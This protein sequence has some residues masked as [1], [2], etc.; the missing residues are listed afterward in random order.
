MAATRKKRSEVMQTR[1]E[2]G[3]VSL[4]AVGV[5]LGICLFFEVLGLV[6]EYV[7]TGLFG[8]FGL[9]AY[10]APF[11]ALAF[12]ILLIVYAANRPQS[13]RT[14]LILLFL[15]LLLTLIHL[16]VRPILGSA[17]Y[18]QYV[19]DAWALGLASRTG[20]GLLGALLCYPAILLLSETGSYIFLIA[21]MLIILLVVTKLSLRK[22]GEQVA[23]TVQAGFQQAS[24]YAA[25]RRS[26][27][28]LYTE[29]LEETAPVPAPRPK[30][31]KRPQPVREPEPDD[32]LTFLPAS[33]PIEK[34][35]ARAARWREEP[36]FDAPPVYEPDPDG[37]DDTPYAEPAPAPV[38]EAPVRRTVKDLKSTPAEQ[39]LKPP[40]RRKEPAPPAEP[41]P[42]P[43]AEAAPY[44]RP[45]CSL[46]NAPKRTYGSKRAESPQE[47][48]KLLEDTLLSFNVSAKVV[49]VSVG[50]VITRFELQP[51]AGVR[52]NRITT[53]ADDIALAL[54]APRVRIEAPI[55]GKAAVGIEVPNRDTAM[56][57]LRDIVE[58]PEFTNAKSDVT[59]ALGKDIAGNVIVA[60][61]A[62]MPHLLIAGAT[63]SGK[64]V[65][66]N[67]IVVS[68][69]YKSSPADM[70]LILIDPKVVELS[71]FGTLPHLRLPVVTDPKKAAG[72]LSG[73]VREM[74][75]RYN[76]F[77]KVG[78]RDIVRYN[79]LQAQPENRLPKLVV[80]ID[81]LADLMMV[82]PDT[83]EDSIC[84]I[85]QLG[86]ACGIHLIVATQRPSAD[87][88]TGLI[89]A[90]I[91][92]RIAFAVAS[93]IDSRIILDMGG[94]EKLLGRGDM[95]FHPNGA[96]KPTRCQAAYVSDDEVDRVVT[97]FQAQSITPQ[98]DEQLMQNVEQVAQGSGAQ[99][100]G[101]QEDDLLGEALRVVL[102]SGQAS[103]SMI[104]RRLRVGYARAARLVDMMEQAG[105]VSGFDGAKP[106]KVLITRAQFEQTF[107]DG[108]QT[109]LPINDE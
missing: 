99:G 8:L 97:F 94:A 42:E 85:A 28:P 92:T 72:A 98:F 45:S 71:V 30:R 22:A 105:Y 63:G 108:S 84:R 13:G 29:A 46:L 74:T 100:N 16:T 107:G 89:K 35:P 59:M 7:T 47:K 64:S 67:D 9:F 43:P 91:P 90:N 83:V 17:N 18:L 37:L 1:R 104:Q 95:L 36:R 70:Q 61:L 87:V 31:G 65:C 39:E 81:E 14:A 20:G 78:A 38:R 109:E 34:K 76:K 12:G 103:I 26:S 32:P 52:V 53:L 69:V 3:G 68:L 73:A 49:N 48:A 41:L 58:S 44:V 19:K 66:I 96:A 75:D 15:L 50:P 82:A 33:G 24:Q 51:A 55:P 27:K 25:E 11:F 80:V 56:V 88:I 4:I 40:A 57:L 102:D 79:E 62:R 77:A 21:G 10:A 86:R 101:K 60:D 54:A 2:I 5:F 93:A 6:G 106:R 23:H